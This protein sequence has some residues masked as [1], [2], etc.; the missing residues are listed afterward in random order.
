MRSGPELLARRCQSAGV[1][2]AIYSSDL[3]FDGASPTAATRSRTPRAAER[4]RA[5]QGGSGARVLATE[6]DVL[7]IRTAAFFSPH[8]RHNFAVHA[9][10][11]LRERRSFAA[12]ADCVVSPTYVPDLVNATLDLL[13]D[14][15]TGV[16]HLANEGAT[17]WAEFGRKVAQATELDPT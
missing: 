14:R 17:S 16:W 11:A 10:D 5:Q 8:D 2:L 15:E 3:V 13:I 4:L 1:P 9:V 12:P 6:A 7:V